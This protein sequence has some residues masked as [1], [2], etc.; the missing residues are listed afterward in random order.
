[1][2]IYLKSGILI[3]SDITFITVMYISDLWTD[4]TPQHMTNVLILKL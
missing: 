4:E 1:M 2:N 3:L